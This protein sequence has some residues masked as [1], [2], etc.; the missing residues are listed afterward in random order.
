MLAVFDD[1]LIDDSGKLLFWESDQIIPCT[2]ELFKKRFPAEGNVQ[3]NGIARDKWGRV[4]GY[5]VTGKR[6]RQIIDA[7]AD[8]TVW[9][10]DNAILPRDPWRMNQGRGV[11]PMLTA[12]AS[13]L[14][15]AV[16][17]GRNGG[18]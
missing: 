4:L 16:D 7:E 9:Q 11:P 10:R 12:A 5:T 6:G 3:D 8:L 2:D 17:I 18:R 1:G 13:L 15:S 14:D